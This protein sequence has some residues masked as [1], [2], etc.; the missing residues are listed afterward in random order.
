MSHRTSATS[1][2][3]STAPPFP[4]S[5]DFQGSD[6][7]I[8]LSPQWLLPKPGEG[9]PGAGTVES[10]VISTPSLSNHSETVKTSGNEDVRDDHKRKDV[11]RPS[12]LDSESGRHDRWRDE[13]RDTKS[14]IR[15]ERWRDG[16]KVLGDARR[17]DRWADNPSS[18]NFGE[19][20]RGTSDRWNDSGNREMNFDQPR[21]NRWTSRW[22]HDE[23]EPEVLHEKKNDSGKNCDLHLDKGSSHISIPGKDE[24]EGARFSPWRSNSL[25]RRGRIEPSHHQN[26]T[27]SKQVPIFSSGRGRGEDT[28]PGANH[29]RGRGEDTV[30]GAN[31]GGGRFGSGGSPINSSYMHSQYPQ[32]VLDKVE[33]ERGEAHPFRYSRTNILDVYRVT[34]V[35]TAI[36]LVDDFA[37]VPPFTQDEPL[38]PL[39]LC[40]PTSEE[41]T[42]L[43]GIDK[44]EI[45]SSS[46]PPVPKDGR[47]ST[48]FTH[49]RQMKLGNAAV[50]DRGE[51]GGSYKVADEVHSNRES[52]FEENSPVHPGTGRHATSQGEQ[53][54]S[55][56]HDSK[57]V[58][59]DVSS[60]NSD[61]KWS[62]QPKDFRTQW[63][64]NLDYLSDTRDVAKW[65]SSEDSIVKR[66]LTGYLDGEL[67]TRRVPQTSPEELSL[68]YK[69]PRGQVQG[70]FKGVDIIGWLEAG[71]FGI[72]LLVRL[73]SAAADSPWLQLVDVMPHLRAKARPPP[74][75]PVTKLDTTEAPA[76]QS[77]G[78]FVNI[79]TGLG[80]VERLR[81]NSMHRL[82]SATEAENRFLESLMSGSKSSSPLENV[83]L[84]EGIQGFIGNNSGNLGP[85]GVDGVNNPYLL[86]QRMALERQRSLPNP[87]P[88][89]PGIDAASLPPKSDVV[90]DASPHSKLMSSLSDNSR[91][92][93]SQ[94]SEL[95]SGIQGLSDRAS[96]GLNN[97]VAGWS[98]Y[99]L[100][101]GL[102]PL[103]NNIDLHRDQN[104][105][106]FG[107]QQQT[108]QASNHLSLNNLRAQT[109]DNPSNVLTAEK[110][111]SSSLSQDPQIVN[112][113]QQ[114]YLLQMHSQ[115]TAP[116]QQMPLLDKLLFLKQQEEQQ[117]LMH[118][119]RQML[120]QVLQGHQSHQHFG[121]LSYGQL[122][123]GGLGMG[124]LHVEP[125]QWQP[126]HENFHSSSQTPVPSVHDELNTK[127]LNISQQES[128]DTSYNKSAESVQLPHQFFGNMSQHK[129]WDTALPEQ[130][131]EKYQKETLPASASVESLLLHEQSRTTEEPNIAQKPFSASD[132]TVKYVEQMSDNNDRADGTLVNAISESAE[133]S[134]PALYVAP[135]IV[136]SSAASPLAGQVGTD[137]SSAASSLAGQVGT[138]VSSTASPLTGQVGTDVEIKPEQ[139]GGNVVSNAEPSVA[140]VRDIEVREPKKAT[141]KKS[142]K[143]KS[144]K[145][146][147]SG[148]AKG[149]L[150][151]V[152]LQQS[153][154]T[155]SEKPNYSEINLKEVN[156]E[157]EDYETHLK[158]TS[159]VDGVS[160]TAIT[161][162]VHHEVSD[163]PATVPESIAETFVENDSKSFSPVASQNTELPAGRAWKPAPGFKA[164]SLLEI[165][166]EEQKRAQTEMP[167]IEVATTVN[168]P[169]VTTPWVGVVANPDPIKVSS[170][171]HKEASNTENLG[172]TKTSQHSKSKKSPLHDLLA[173]DTE[174]FN[175][176]DGTG[177]D[178]ILFSQYIAAH[179]EP[180]D[181]GEFI[182]AKD[183]RRSRKKSTKSKGS[184][185]KISK[186]VASSETPISSSPIEKGKS[187]RSVQQEKELPT[188][189]SGPSLGDFV[190]WREEPT[191]PS[192]SPAWTIDSGRVH[193]PLSLRDILKEQE[194][195]SSAVPPNQ[196]PTPQKSQPAQTAQSSGPSRTI[197]AP[198]SLK[199]AS[200]SHIN[201]EASHSKHK[202]DDDMFWGPVEQSKQETKQS[203][204]PQLASQGSWG[205]KNVH[206]KGN[207]S[208]SLSHQKS[209]SSK[210]TE[211]LLSSSPVSSQS[212]LK[213][214]KDVMTRNSEAMDFRIWCENECVRLIGTKDTSF[215][216]FCSKQSK[217]EAEMFL[218]EN[219]GSYDPDH[220]FIDKFLN[221]MELL[222]SEVLETAFLT[223]N[224]RKVVGSII[225]GNT[226]LQNLGQ[227]DGSPLKGG[228][229]GKKGKKVSAA[230]LGFN[231]VSN[232]IMMGEIQTVED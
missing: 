161:N 228:K 194:K 42:V 31:H 11:F 211:R 218:K 193:K 116:A 188:I 79:H 57:N 88:Y 173:E 164:K 84:S 82:G 141:E 142:K 150:K 8:P 224:D 170:Q 130:I 152:T 171:N 12:V 205:S 153:K 74:G 87:Y 59:G 71:Y 120:S 83:T 65:Q 1:L 52:A 212:S 146:Q 70:P 106:P 77:A 29:G 187:S 33:R 172:K 95:I 167:V 136:V 55:L 109:A 75:F 227:A 134:K 201:S 101:A 96:T 128:Q 15:Q 155:E 27:P 124:N 85:S 45:V 16:D 179:S 93:Q 63:E 168:S 21:E 159:G 166:Q 200:S 60:K 219:L 47:N 138:D 139:L 49:S 69:D 41:L 119:Q 220:E 169:S 203:N 6:N 61:I 195:K 113:L 102:N 26:M 117:L 72:D 178:S 206:M 123:G 158:Q 92:F 192:P 25:Q 225:S 38:A 210:P 129:G 131:N 103:Q 62:H 39:A 181:E 221:Y 35:H 147:S 5:K 112:M 177:L 189:P 176:R 66:Q 46:A 217:S 34:D 127:S 163:L 30:P 207:S 126:P 198:T 104:F 94:N 199:T 133:Y 230:V 174:I 204:F 14:S 111:F 105:I 99:P 4:I 209:G 149:L 114:Q 162:V 53:A 182:E 222:P 54:S 125:S 20:R 28:L 58:P 24:K 37:Q 78:T 89:W 98:N 76:R 231:V 214:K 97:N 81:N 108:F 160:R 44:G 184:G 132:C 232:R 208:G 67:E 13:E 115:A 10:H 64:N 183:T 110:L 90:P 229:K 86:A 137:V 48:E 186:P 145:S 9:K 165:Q 17:V 223:Q 107:V 122:Q 191:S 140:D 100:Q 32:T 154:N 40:A 22:G 175:E 156:R 196:F 56:M 80:E 143:Q 226:N 148:Q 215:L 213:L 180:I 118:Q 190:L 23:K 7:P 151:N 50:Q 3:V 135:V 157:E 91:Q 18:R 144:S 51:G 202:G 197:S 19:T 43:K 216:E 185:S 2:H 121:G 68:F 73:E 36:K